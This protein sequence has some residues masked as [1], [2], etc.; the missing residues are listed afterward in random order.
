MAAGPTTS[1]SGARHGIAPRSAAL[2]PGVSPH[3]R[4]RRAR[5][6]VALVLLLAVTIGAVGWWLGEGRWTDVPSLVGQ[7]EKTAMGLVQ[8]AGLDPV[9]ADEQFS[10]DVPDG[11]VISA[12]PDGGRLILGSDVELVVSKG[13]ERFSVDV[14]LVGKPLAEVQA[15]LAD[16]PTP[17]VPASGFSDTVPEGSVI[18]FD[19]PAGTDLQREQSV[20]V[21]VSSGRAP[22]KVPDVVGQSPEAATAN[23]ED[24]G[25][26]VTRTE[27][28]SADV[29]AGTVMAVSPGPR[30]AAQ[31]FGS[32]VTVQVSVGLPRVTVPDVRN[33]SQQDAVA[34]LAGVGLKADAETFIAGDRVFQQSPRA[35]EVVDQ[36]STVRILISF[37]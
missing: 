3:I 6:A 2:R 35:G 32:T 17:L 14:D 31:P 36:G 10:E 21:V 16:Q 8:E 20:T 11:T 13:P 18:S 19:P 7:P 26:T 37:G 23:L 5:L 27:G 12:E 1:V 33:K 34:A 24:R 30:D 4:R 9:L 25:F 28:R 15:A 22:V 29:P